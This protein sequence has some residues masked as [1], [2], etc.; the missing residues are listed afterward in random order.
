PVDMLSWYFSEGGRDR[1][2]RD[3]YLGQIDYRMKTERLPRLF[4]GPGAIRFPAGWYRLSNIRDGGL[5]FGFYAR[6]GGQLIYRDHVAILGD[7]DA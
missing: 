5:E 1:R 2:W 7:S 4:N 6:D 3:Y